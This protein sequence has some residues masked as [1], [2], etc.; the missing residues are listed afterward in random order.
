MKTD[1]RKCRNFCILD[2]LFYAAST[3]FFSQKSFGKTLNTNKNIWNGHQLE[4]SKKKKDA[5]FLFK[6][7]SRPFLTSASLFCVKKSEFWFVS[8]RPREK[9]KAPTKRVVFTLIFLNDRLLEFWERLCLFAGS[10]YFSTRTKK[11]RQN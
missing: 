10:S 1:H 11:K 2:P 5:R 8:N 3:F 4:Y 6:W 7:E 9:K